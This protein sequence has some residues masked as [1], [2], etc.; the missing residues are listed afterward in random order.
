MR[1]S[2]LRSS[3]HLLLL[4]ILLGLVACSRNS[5]QDAGPKGQ[6]MLW[7]A[8]HNTEEQVLNS[9]LHKFTEVYPDISVISVP[10]ASDTLKREYEIKAKQALGPDILIGSQ[11]WTPSLADAGLIRAISEESIDPT[12]YLSAALG[13]LRYQD[14]LYGVPL[15]VQTKLGCFRFRIAT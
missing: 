2:K 12:A 7:H 6:V 13:T 15:S 5:S 10:F 1:I 8:W 11:S 3:R 9:L 14:K 4:L